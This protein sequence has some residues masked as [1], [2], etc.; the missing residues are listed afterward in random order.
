MV[1]AQAVARGIA[2][3][4]LTKKASDV[5]MMDLR[6]LTSMADYFVV[7]S[8]DSDIQVKAIADGVEE[9]MDAVGVSPWHIESGSTNW[10]LLDFV[11]V[12]LHVFHKSTRQFYS[13]EKLWGD[14]K[15]ERFSDEGVIRRRPVRTLKRKVAKISKSKKAT[16]VR[17]KS[18]R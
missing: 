5:L 10:I 7:C 17:R 13:L 18:T 4:T 14:A 3:L 6:G 1:N 8:G 12:V 2:K 15:I 11:D 9:G 16:K